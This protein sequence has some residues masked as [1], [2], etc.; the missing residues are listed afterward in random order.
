M[1]DSQSGKAFRFTFRNKQKPNQTCTK[2]QKSNNTTQKPWVLQEFLLTEMLEAMALQFNA[3][4]GFFMDRL[5][6]VKAALKSQDGSQEQFVM[7]CFT[8]QPSCTVSLNFKTSQTSCKNSII[9]N[10]HKCR[11]VVLKY[12]Y[13]F[14]YICIYLYA[15]IS[16]LSR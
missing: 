6:N 2:L 11:L 9:P 12:M 15:Y 10:F 16:I 1:Q 13:I 7:E 4:H 3:L 14:L 8:G 5:E